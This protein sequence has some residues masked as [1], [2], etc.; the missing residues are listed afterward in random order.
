MNILENKRVVLLSAVFALAFA[1]LTYVGYD[2]SAQYSKTQAELNKIGEKFQ[3]YNEAEL[4]PT[5]ANRKAIVAACKDVEKISADMQAEMEK[6][7]AYCHGDGKLLSPVDFQNQVRSTIAEVQNAANAAGCK[8]SAPAMDLGMASFKNAAATEAE[9]PFRSFQLK[10][11]RRVAEAIIDSGAPTLDKIY[12]APLP[13]EATDARKAKNAPYFPLS[14]QVAFNAKRSE[15]TDGQTDEKLSVLP[16]VIN[17]L[18]N[19]KDFFLIITGVAVNS[20]ASLPAMDAYQAPSAPVAKGDDLAD[21]EEAEKKA[22]PEARVIA[23]RKTGN[24]DETIRV[25]LNMQVLYFNPSK[26]K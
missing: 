6:Y 16:Q 25:H 13:E 24:P 5:P 2:R 14:F 22:E 15:V 12:C 26:G 3:D 19:D 20:E 8:L 11:V 7:A 21:G 9:V 18:M 4:P 17:K 10:A 23:V 1:G